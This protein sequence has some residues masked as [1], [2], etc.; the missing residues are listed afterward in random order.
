MS[1]QYPLFVKRDLDGFFG[2]FI[3]NLVQLLAILFLC[4]TFCGMQ[5]DDSR[6]LFQ[7]ILPGA[8]LSILA[9]NIFY[10]WQA[11]RLAKKEGRSDVTA[12][13][14][15]INTP[16]LIV[17]VYFVMGPVY[18]KT[19]SVE[20]AWQ[21]GLI[22]CFGSGV[23][24]VLGAFVA[25]WIR[26]WTPRAAL[27]STLAGIAIGFISMTFA[28][29]IYQKPFIG[30]LPMALI[31]VAL[32]S[33]VRFPLGLPGGFVAV[34]AGTALAWLMTLVGHF[35]PGAPEW[36]VYGALDPSRPA[37]ELQSAG[38]RLPVYSGNVLMDVLRDPSSW[39]GFLSVIVPM[40]LF[41][42]IGSLQNIESA[43]ASGDSYPTAPSMLANGIGTIVASLFGSCFPTTIYIG[44]PGWKGL[45]ARA[46]YSTLNGLVIVLLS[47]GGLIGLV[48]SVI[49]M[50]AGAAI[51][52]WIGIII[53]AQAFTATP[54]HHGPAV[55]VGLFPAIA[56]W[57]ATVMVGA[58]GEAG[59]KSVQ[60][61]LA[62]PT[63]AAVATDV[64]EPDNSE[65]E[66]PEPESPN[67]EADA[68]APTT[69]E[70]A[71]ADETKPAPAGNPEA[72][73]NGFLINGLLLMERG[74]IFT[75]MILAAIA[76]CLL[77][78]KFTAAA[79]WSLIA[80]ALTWLGVMHAYQISGNILDFLFRF[81]AAGEGW[82]E[83]RANGI[84]VNYLLWAVAFFAFG[85]YF[86]RHPEAESAGH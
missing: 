67:A 2:L 83:F 13:P 28:L 15:G 42:V 17:Y 35:W 31:F 52:L 39:A 80:A 20:A 7:F 33:K 54:D 25:G 26:K 27:L 66:V 49:P 58:F 77:D 84:A 19:K 21:M 10:A 3:D 63:P 81:A 4:S 70:S 86:D 12:L 73:V 57:G 51:V 45:G 24:E 56:A 1:A 69:D 37:A 6:Y 11:H 38:W 53:T 41:N 60:E 48:A 61:L 50:E 43:E 65:S 85:R 75:C 46:G 74:Y 9:G 79:I 18:A 44:H 5:G 62:G 8:A 72:K 30:L 40:G 59:G 32:F 23:I 14:Y 47:L 36:L 64:E 22:A 29:E 68:A 16:S 78:R 76:A 55:A 71:P 34:L 82:H